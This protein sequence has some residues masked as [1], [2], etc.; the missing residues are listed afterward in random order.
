MFENLSMGC[1]KGTSRVGD[2]GKHASPAKTVK[3]K[4]RRMHYYNPTA[5]PPFIYLPKISKSELTHILLT[6]KLQGRYR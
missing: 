4:A 5:L 1:L 6:G 3:Y 2:D